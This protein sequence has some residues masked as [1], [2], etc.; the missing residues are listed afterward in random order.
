MS[1]TYKQW[2]V[3]QLAENGRRD[4]HLAESEARAQY[5]DWACRLVLEAALEARAG[6]NILGGQHGN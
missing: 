1:D 4:D 3:K 6:L 5:T 2:L